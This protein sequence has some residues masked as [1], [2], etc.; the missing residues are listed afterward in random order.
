MDARKIL[1]ILI[2]AVLFGIFTNSLAEALFNEPD[3]NNYCKP[4]T[5]IYEKMAPVSV[6][7][8]TITGCNN[9]TYIEPT[10]EERDNC[11][12][13]DLAPVYS[14]NNCITSYKCETC[15]KEFQNAQ[16]NYNFKI[17]LVTALLGLVAIILGLY[18]PKDINSLNEWIG[19]GFMFGG[20]ISVF[21]GTARYF[22]DM[23][24]I[25]R[26]IIIFIELILVILI[27]YKKL[28]DKK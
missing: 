4:Y 8:Q 23:H 11:K 6:P 3:Y 2:I 15:N 21:I 7:T 25:V 18:L 27:T 28:K 22:G 1:V 10:T 19:T 9:C 13:G 16:S 12:D 5:S 14:Q 24:K 20:L 26:P 17:F